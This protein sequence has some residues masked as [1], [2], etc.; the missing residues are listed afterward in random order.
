M[1]LIEIFTETSLVDSYAAAADQADAE[2]VTR[3]EGTDGHAALKILV[4]TGDPQSL[5]D[6]LQRLTPEDGKTRIVMMVPELVL[7]QPKS[8]ENSPSRSDATT[9]EELYKQIEQ[10]AR[11]DGVFLVLVVLSTVVAALGLLSDNVAVIIGAMMIAPLLGPNLSLALAVALGDLVLLRRAVVANAI[12][13]ALTVG[14]GIT[15]GVA[16][17]G[18]LMS[19]E[20]LLRTDVGLDSVVLALTAGAAAVLSLTT[21]L[22]TVLVGVVIAAAFL[23]PAATIGL[24]VGAHN[25]P[26]AIGATTLLAVNIVCVSLA[27]QIVFLIR[28]VR[29]R[30]W[31]ERARVRQSVA[32]N[33]VLW[34]L[35]LAGLVAVIVL[36]DTV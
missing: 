24:M 5:L 17:P 12:G 16:W 31:L 6:T 20:L 15:V 32:I 29:P 30:T 3:N 19:H 36:G 8:D 33:L 35:M 26:L 9:R 11:V 4:T 22:P 34:V 28:G 27:A 23:P 7:P 13:V 21:R 10:D 25:W 2:I 18:T 1:H 14:T